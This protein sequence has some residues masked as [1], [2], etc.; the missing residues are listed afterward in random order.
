MKFKKYS[1]NN[2]I[3]INHRKIIMIYF[4]NNYKLYNFLALI[5]FD[6]LI[7]K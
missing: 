7:Y 3:K 2:K 5:I 1:M 6:D 4:I